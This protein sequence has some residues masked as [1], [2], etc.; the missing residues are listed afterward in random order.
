MTQP[1]P[2]YSSALSP[3]VKAMA[4]ALCQVRHGS[5][6]TNGCVVR[7]EEEW[8]AEG[9]V[10]VLDWMTGYKLVRKDNRR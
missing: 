2:T 4:R 8:E 7:G 5:E 6:G 10:G 3:E 9:L 1:E